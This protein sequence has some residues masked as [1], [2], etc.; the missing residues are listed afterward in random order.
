[1]PNYDNDGFVDVY[2]TNFGKN[3]LYRN[4]G[5][6]YAESNLLF[7]GD[8]R[9]HFT[10]VTEQAGDFTRHVECTRGLAFGD[11]D[12]D[13][14]IDLVSNTIGHTLR[15]FHN[16]ATTENHWL[17]VRALNRL[18]IGANWCQSV[19]SK[20]RRRQSCFAPAENLVVVANRQRAN[21]ARPNDNTQ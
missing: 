10:N 20:H 2:V 12:S 1:M 4:H 8:G 9:G 6:P 17:T 3:A 5:K 19:L 21:C 11:F 13:G 16:V 14:R 18:S 15:L 7:R